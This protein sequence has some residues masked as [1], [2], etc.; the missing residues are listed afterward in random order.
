MTGVQTCALP[1]YKYVL[2]T[3]KG[4]LHVINGSVLFGTTDKPTTFDVY[5]PTLASIHGNLDVSGNVYANNLSSD[6]RIKNN[7]KNSETN[8]LGIIKQ[9]Q[10]KQFDKK[11]DG[12]HYD[13]GYIAQEMEKIDSNFVIIRPKTEKTEERYYINELPIIATATKAIQEQQEQ[14]EELK[15][16]IEKLKGE[17]NG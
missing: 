8:A 10:H 14:I 11:D 1:I 5:V 4:D 3:D 9:I 15:K 2:L 13:I 17:K 12:K 7:I 6:R 16:E